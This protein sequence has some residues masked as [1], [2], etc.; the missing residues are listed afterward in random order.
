V[1]F[2]TRKKKPSIPVRY[3]GAQSRFELSNNFALNKHLLVLLSGPEPQR[4]I[5]ENELL[6]QL[7]NYTEPV[8][9]LRGLPGNTD[10]PNVPSNIVIYNHLAS[11][12]LEEAIM[13]SEFIISRCGYSTVMDMMI[14]QK[15]TILIPTPGQTEQEYLSSHL[16]KNRMALSIPQSKFKL[17]NA[18]ELARSFNYQKFDLIKTNALENAIGDLIDKLKLPGEK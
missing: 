16:M 12:Q 15:K 5:L 1:I 3:I 10:L 18:I 4:T 8:L 17:K 14:I 9:F 7:A 6:D 11:D 13:S 2:H